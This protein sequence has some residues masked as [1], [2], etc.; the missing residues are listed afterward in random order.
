M[1]ALHA[2]TAVTATVTARLIPPLPTFRRAA[3]AAAVAVPAAVHG[4]AGRERVRPWHTPLHKCSHSRQFVKLLKRE[5]HSNLTFVT[6][7][8]ATRGM[9]D[10]GSQ[11]A[12][13]LARGGWCKSLVQRE[14]P[15]AWRADDARH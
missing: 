13:R 15:R 1:H 14:R 4:H 2:V 9:T 8:C 5:Q 7:S 10:G 11:R 6:S 3:V 12:A